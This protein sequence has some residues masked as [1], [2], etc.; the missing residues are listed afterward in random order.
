MWKNIILQ[1]SVHSG[2][3]H[4][5]ESLRALIGAYCKIISDKVDAADVYWDLSRVK[6]TNPHSICE[7]LK[8]RS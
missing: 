3:S 4:D 5:L 6:V 1:Q 7:S 8:P 2:Y